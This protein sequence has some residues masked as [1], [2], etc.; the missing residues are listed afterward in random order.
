MKLFKKEIDDIDKEIAI[1]KKRKKLDVKLFDSLVRKKKELWNAY[2]LDHLEKE[3][4]SFEYAQ[5]ESSKIFKEIL[6]EIFKLEK[7][8][9]ESKRFM[10]PMSFEKLS[11]WVKEE[12]TLSDLFVM[13]VAIKDIKRLLRNIKQSGRK[14]K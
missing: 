1:V 13:P 7:Q 12:D 4:S 9:K 3:K 2:F 5:Q 6:D 10:K 8:I 14:G 11:E